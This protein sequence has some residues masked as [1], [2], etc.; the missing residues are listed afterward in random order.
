M[1]AKIPPNNYQY[2]KDT[3]RVVTR[4]GAT[5]HLDLHDMV[6]W[7]VYYDFEV[8]AMTTL[9]SL[10]KQGDWIV[11]IGA[12][13]GA[14]TLAAADRVGPAGHVFSFEPHPDNFRRLRHN[15]SLNN[16][17]NLTLIQKGL[18]ERATTLPMTTERED[19]KGLYR[20]EELPKKGNAALV[21][22]VTLDEYLMDQ[23][24]LSHI[25]LIK[26]DVEGYEMKVLAG[27][28]N[29]IQRFRPTLFV[30]VVDSQLVEFGDSAEELVSAISQLGYCAVDSESGEPVGPGTDFS[31]MRDVV[32]YPA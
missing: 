13:M 24:P 9:F 6:D 18:G 20:V 26:I 23:G 31:K 25:D 7:Y 5:F 2:K 28:K 1:F 21:E 29:T 16:Y 15:V 4:R 27:A 32:G 30:E 12:N 3:I 10:M 19:N 17:S 11:D 14:V 8:P 22:V